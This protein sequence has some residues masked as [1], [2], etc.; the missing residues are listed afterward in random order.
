MFSENCL[1]S[2]VLTYMPSLLQIWITLW[3]YNVVWELTILYEF[4]IITCYLFVSALIGGPIYHVAIKYPDW[5]SANYLR[6]A[7][8]ERLT[9][10]NL[11]VRRSS[12]SEF[13][14]LVNMCLVE[15][16]RH[17]QPARTGR[18]CIWSC[19]CH[20]GKATPNISKKCDDRIQM[21]VGVQLIE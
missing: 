18:A 8:D 12:L 6:E 13:I 15:L 9:F 16:Y 17:K 5:M 4:V 3:S 2:Q 21:V 19:S 7:V 14:K 1:R 20:V 11:D 10:S